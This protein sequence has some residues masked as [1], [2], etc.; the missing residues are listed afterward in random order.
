MAGIDLKDGAPRWALE[1]LSH[2]QLVQ[3]HQEVSAELIRRV[4]RATEADESTKREAD[5]GQPRW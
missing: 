1:E 4:L 5:R 3:V 2:A